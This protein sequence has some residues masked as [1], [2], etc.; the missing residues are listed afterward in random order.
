MDSN[1]NPNSHSHGDEKTEPSANPPVSQPYLER[2]D[3]GVRCEVCG[4]AAATVKDVDHD[5]IYSNDLVADGGEV[6]ETPPEGPAERYAKVDVIAPDG[7]VEDSVKVQFDYEQ[8]LGIDP[9]EWAKKGYFASEYA[10]ELV[11][12][13]VGDDHYTTREDSSSQDT[14]PLPE[15]SIELLQDIKNTPVDSLI[16]VETDTDQFNGR[17]FSVNSSVFDD[18]ESY[19][20]SIETEFFGSPFTTAEIH[21]DHFDEEKDDLIR[22]NKIGHNESGDR[23]VRHAGDLHS[24]TVLE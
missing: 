13:H 10:L 12:L 2:T 23:I 15:S 9:M 11:Y 22:F 1:S 24:I 5:C 18:R 17:V 4:N 21:I 14:E 19:R 20:L 7:S 3:D 8:P 16:R 6:Q